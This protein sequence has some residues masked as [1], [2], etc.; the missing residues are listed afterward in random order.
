M[1]ADDIRAAQDANR[2]GGSRPFETLVRRQ[3]QGVTDKGF[4]RRP[5]Q[6]RIAQAADLAQ[7]V[8]E[9]EVLLDRLAEA[10]AGSRMM[11]SSG[12][13]AAQAMATESISS[14]L[15]SSIRF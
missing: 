4:A 9:F 7:A 15:T 5:K 2:H 10:D 8:D 11:R 6:D 14:R 12:I 1:N 3:V 13:P